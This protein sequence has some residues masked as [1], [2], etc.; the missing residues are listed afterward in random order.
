MTNKDIYI[1]KWEDTRWLV[2]SSFFL[3]FHR[4]MHLLLIYTLE[5][6]KWDDFKSF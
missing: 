1:A 3:L 5:H 2:L 6:L 4:F